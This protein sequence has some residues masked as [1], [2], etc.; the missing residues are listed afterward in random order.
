MESPVQLVWARKGNEQSSLG[1][2]QIEERKWQNGKSTRDCSHQFSESYLDVLTKGYDTN[3]FVTP[4]WLCTQD[5]FL[6]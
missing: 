2:T 3:W 5:R 4:Y 1:H 6:A